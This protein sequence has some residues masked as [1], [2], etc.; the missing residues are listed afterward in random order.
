MWTIWTITFIEQGTK[1]LIGNTLDQNY[2]YIGQVR[3]G[4]L[5]NI[6]FLMQP[7]LLPIWDHCAIV[8]R[9]SKL[10]IFILS[11]SIKKYFWTFVFSNYWPCDKFILTVCTVIPQCPISKENWCTKDVKKT[12][13]N[14]HIFFIRS[15]KQTT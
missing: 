13:K 8:E 1:L 15:R 11:F 3:L 9:Y 12:A 7:I 6:Y 2:F 14:S 10:I 5:G 4:C